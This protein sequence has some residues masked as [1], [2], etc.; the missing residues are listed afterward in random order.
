MSSLP[1]TDQQ[2]FFVVI[3]AF[4]VGG[5]IRGWR[6]ELISLVFIL[7]AAALVHPSTNQSVTQFLTRLPATIGYLISG[8]ARPATVTTAAAP[9]NPFFTLLL[10]ALIGVAG[11]YIGNRAFPKPAAQHERF[12]GILP[13]LV[14]AAA[15]LWY[16]NTGGFFAK[17]TSGQT[18][19]STVFMLP[20]PTNY[21]P[22]LFVI[23]VIAVVVALISA[24]TKKSAPPA[25]KK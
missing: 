6:R 1:F 25:A 20:D 7:L 21:V 19:F 17:T 22:V 16:I 23:A 10:F 5:F 15:V 14:S 2:C 8:T 12:I 13:A 24:R 4:A 3:F 9:A 18:T 11:Y